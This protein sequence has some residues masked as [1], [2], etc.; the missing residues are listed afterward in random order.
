MNSRTFLDGLV[1]ILDKDDLAQLT[2]RNTEHLLKMHLL[3]T[4]SANSYTKHEECYGQ[5]S[6]WRPAVFWPLDRKRRATKCSVVNA[7]VRR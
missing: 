7:L 6:C 1:T 2:H 3:P 4:I 5:L